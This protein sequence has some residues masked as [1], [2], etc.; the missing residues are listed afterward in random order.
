MATDS[1]VRW[2]TVAGLAAPIL[3]AGAVI[4][5]GILTSGYSH[6]HEPISALTQA[7][8]AAKPLIDPLFALYNL[9]LVVFAIGL[10]R[11]FANAGPPISRLAPT[12]LGVAALAGLVMWAFP[13]DPIGAG[14]T[15]P[16][17]VHIL[18][19]GVQS[20]STIVAILWAAIALRRRPGWR[21]FSVFSAACLV[22]LIAAGGIGAWA[23]GAGAP[24][25][26][27]FER[28]TI[29]AFEVWLFSL[30]LLLLK[31]PRAAPAGETAGPP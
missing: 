2:A 4:L 26:G 31:R 21:R 30:A 1:A 16:G 18:L 10:R 3:Y 27:L 22:V 6:L 7:G 8:A 20:V 29:G 11:G 9:L 12:A 14:M 17:A 28:I 23:A 25:M 5:G 15:V 13:M 19:A 24:F